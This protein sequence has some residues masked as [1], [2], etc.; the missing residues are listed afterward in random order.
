MSKNSTPIMI[1][2]CRRMNS[3]MVI[4]CG[5][6][7]R[8]GVYEAGLDAKKANLLFAFF[9]K[10]MVGAEGLEPPTYAV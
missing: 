9:I 7:Q 5:A 10:L 8:L 2:L 4:S 3:N 6:I 1:L